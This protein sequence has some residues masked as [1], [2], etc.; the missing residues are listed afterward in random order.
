MPPVISERSSAALI[1]RYLKARGVDRVFGLCGGHI[2][3]IWMRLA[4]EGIAI[5]DVRD[6]RAAVYMAHAHSEITGRLGVALL[7][8]GPGVTNGMTGIANAHVAR[9]SILIL[10]GLPPQPQ[11]NRGALQD[12]VHTAFVAPLTRYARTVRDPAHVLPEMYEA[13]ARAYG[14]GGGEPGPVYLDFPVDTLR[15]EVPQ[16]VELEEYF[17][18]PARAAV[19]PDPGRVRASADALWSARRPLVISGRGARAY[20]EAVVKFLDATGALYL[21]TGETRGL[22]PESH[23]SVVSAVRG[24]VMGD[25]DLVLT[26]GRRLDFQIA[27]GSP[28]VFGDATF[29]RIADVPSELRDNRPGEVGVYASVGPAL[30]AIVEAAG[31]R[32]PAIDRDWAK[33]HRATHEERVAK[34]GKM[35]REAPDGTDGRMHP[36]R[37]LGALRDALPSDAI[38]VVDGGDFLSFA[39]VGINATTMLDPGSLGCIGIGTGFG[40]ASALAASQRLVAVLTGDGAFGFNAMELDTAVRHN[41]PI[42]VVVAN[43]GSWAIEVR[44]QLDSYGEVV[45]TKLRHSDYAMMARGL[46]MHAQRV[47]RAEDLPAAIADAMARRPALLDVV[48][49]PDAVSADSKSGLAWVPDLQPLAAWDTGERAFRASS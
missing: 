34:F 43:N 35:L 16:A 15:A 41:V 42:L 24:A 29:V 44:D 4:K 32:S 47:D 27:Y 48:V 3:P 26:L 25:A 33:K 40:I 28:A 7:T 19:L 17:A 46:G 11:E 39:R 14:E 8:A 12:I 5:V 38:V 1:A 2:M 18:V 22:V 9:A 21:E 10:S 30:E 36:N 13:I 31:D 20:G 23:P 45:G 49:T 6:E 37:L